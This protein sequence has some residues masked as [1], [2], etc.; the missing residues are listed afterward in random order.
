MLS[1]VEIESMELGTAALLGTAVEL[2]TAVDTLVDRVV[3]LVEVGI[4]YLID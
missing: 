4:V 2:G 3:V 1:T